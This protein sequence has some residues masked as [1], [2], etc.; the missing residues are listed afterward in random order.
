MT[1]NRVRT[2]QLMLWKDLYITACFS[3]ID[4]TVNVVV[5]ATIWCVW[6]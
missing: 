5:V 4:V 3:G 1:W 2:G 6:G